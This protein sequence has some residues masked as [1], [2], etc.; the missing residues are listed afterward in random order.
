VHD[1]VCKYT[2]P[3]R[4]THHVSAVGPF[5][6][7]A[8]HPPPQCAAACT[9]L[10]I[11]HST[12]ASDVAAIA[13]TAEQQLVVPCSALQ[14]RRTTVCAEVQVCDVRV[15]LAESGSVGEGR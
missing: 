10:C 8:L 6:P 13:G 7:D 9:P 3:L 5:R 2:K 11:P 15:S 14:H 1:S 4:T 12:C